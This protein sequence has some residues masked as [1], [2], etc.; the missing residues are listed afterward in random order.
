MK[1]IKGD[2]YDEMTKEVKIQNQQC[3]CVVA[4]ARTEDTK[5]VCKE[6]REQKTEGHCHCRR[7]QKVRI[8]NENN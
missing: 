4:W 1:I 2:N 6:F 3:P 7:Y 5:C 8:N